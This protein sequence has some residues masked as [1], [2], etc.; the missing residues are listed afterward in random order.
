MGTNRE[1]I[2]AR[3]GHYREH[4]RRLEELRRKEQSARRNQRIADA[5]D[6]LDT[7]PLF[8][9]VEEMIHRLQVRVHRLNA[10]METR[11]YDSDDA[12]EPRECLRREEDLQESQDVREVHGGR[13]SRDEHRE[14]DQAQAELQRIRNAMGRYQTR[15]DELLQHLEDKKTI[16]PQQPGSGRPRS[17]ASGDATGQAS[18]GKKATGGEVPSGNKPPSGDEPTAGGQER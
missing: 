4:Y 3:K 12:M 18:A 14:R 5:L 2:D 1:D 6:A 10:R 13:L 16:G 8:D 9:A 7:R 11:E 15:V 17:R